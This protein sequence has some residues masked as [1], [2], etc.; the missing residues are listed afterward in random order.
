MDEALSQ[1]VR[2][3]DEDRWLASRFAPAAARDKLIALYAVNYEIAHVAEVAR[4]PGIGVIRLAWWR[5][6]VA[7]IAQ[8]KSA[9]AHPALAA[10]Q[11]SWGGGVD[12][13]AFAAMIEARARDL[14]GEA[15]ESANDLE[16]Y[17]D[18]TAGL[19]MRLAMA[20]CAPVTAD[21]ELFARHAGRAWGYA[22]LARTARRAPVDLAAHALAAYAEAKPL[23]RALASDVFPAIGYVAFTPAYLR[24]LQGARAPALFSKQWKLIAASATGRI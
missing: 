16:L 22:G 15:F 6:G 12:A 11:Q 17:V 23:A 9:R 7:E 14:E 10:L 4:E 19:L 18:A 24:A 1:L 20:A 5:D 8:G 2:R 13:D 3:V 21:A